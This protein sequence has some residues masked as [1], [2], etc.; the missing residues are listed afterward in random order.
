MH[1]TIAYNKKTAVKHGFC[2][3]PLSCA[4]ISLN[5]DVAR[6][7]MKVPP[8]LKNF[9]LLATASFVFL[10]VFLDSP[11]AFVQWQLTRQLA[12]LRENKDYYRGKLEKI[13]QGYKSVSTD[14]VLLEKMA[15]EKYM[16]KQPDEDVYV[17]RKK[18]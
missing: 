15:R 16:M 11:G 2:I 17:V 13:K 7:Q 18:R 3:F 4:E 8:L 1:P 10:V 5:C 14:S 6:C 9:Y 12:R